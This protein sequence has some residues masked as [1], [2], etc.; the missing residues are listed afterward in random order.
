[1]ESTIP[2]GH[3]IA[4]A[5][6]VPLD[7][8]SFE[9]MELLRA[10]LRQWDDDISAGRC[11]KAG[12]D[13]TQARRDK[14]PCAEIKNYLVEISF[15]ALPDAKE[16]EA[17]K[18]LPTSFSLPPQTVDQLRDAAARILADSPDFQ[19]LLRDLR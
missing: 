15:D 7:Q 1:M 6:S 13:V 17:L 2:L 8:Y 11:A 18:S 3:T 14:D 4:T 16:R 12:K 9:T 5:A 10:S 19:E